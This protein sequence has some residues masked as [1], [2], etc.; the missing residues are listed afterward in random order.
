MKSEEIKYHLRAKHL[1]GF[2][3]DYAGHNP[4]SKTHLNF[5]LQAA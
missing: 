2:Y 3:T 1:N 5:L 4:A